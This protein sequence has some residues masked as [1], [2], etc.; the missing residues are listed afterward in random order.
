MR[1]R[2][3]EKSSVVAINALVWCDIDMN[4][5]IGRK[6]DLKELIKPKRKQ[7]LFRLINGGSLVE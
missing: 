1:R 2:W 3:R 4:G 5:A 7:S 6:S